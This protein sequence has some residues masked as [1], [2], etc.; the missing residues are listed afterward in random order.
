MLLAAVGCSVL[1]VWQLRL[2]GAV[3]MFGALGSRVVMGRSPST[4][5]TTENYSIPK[6][7]IQ[8]PNLR[9]ATRT[10]K[11]FFTHFG[12][13]VTRFGAFA[14]SFRRVSLLKSAWMVTRISVHP[15]SSR[16]G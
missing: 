5:N 12:V 3:R 16:R 6:Y 2:L 15:Y 11:A 1:A 13:K 4:N 7:L 9:L 10:W 14:Y 8:G